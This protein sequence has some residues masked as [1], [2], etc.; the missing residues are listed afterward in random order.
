[1]HKLSPHQLQQYFWRGVQVDEKVVWVEERL[2][3]TLAADDQIG[4][5][6]AAR[7]GLGDEVRSQF[8][9]VDSSKITLETAVGNRCRG[10][11]RE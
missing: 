5:S 7:P 1:M 3:E 9:H 10:I 2:A 4:E 8:G 6:A 11:L